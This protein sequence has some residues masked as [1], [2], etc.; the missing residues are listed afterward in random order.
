LNTAI[1]KVAQE[2]VADDPPRYTGE[3]LIGRAFQSQWEKMLENPEKRENDSVGTRTPEGWEHCPSSTEDA[4][5]DFL[6]PGQEPAGGLATPPYESPSNPLASPLPKRARTDPY[7]QRKAV[8]SGLFGMADSSSVGSE[9]DLALVDDQYPLLID[10]DTDSGSS[11][12]EQSDN[13]VEHLEDAAFVRLLRDKISRADFANLEE[14]WN[15]GLSPKPLYSFFHVKTRCRHWSFESA[16]PISFLCSVAPNQ[17]YK[18]GG[19]LHMDISKGVCCNCVK[20][21]QE[22]SEWSAYVLSMQN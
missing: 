16:K 11:L 6:L 10:V 17:R 13:D 1:A 2:I 9:H 12:S 15:G 3:T 21:A 8:G 4:G 14:Q 18:P 5:E 7:A 22:C 20:K 19:D